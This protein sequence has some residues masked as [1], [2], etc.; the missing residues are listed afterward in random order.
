[1]PRSGRS[2][3]NVQRAASVASR[4]AVRITSRRAASSAVGVMR[5]TLSRAPAQPDARER[6]DQRGVSCLT[7]RRTDKPP[8]ND[9]RV[10]RA[11]SHAVDR[12]AIIDAV[13]IKGE[14]SPAIARG[15]A[16]WS[17]RIDQLGAG[18]K[19]YQH[20]PREARRLLAEAGFPNGS[21]PS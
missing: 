21:R 6:L 17:A 9:V 3:R 19:Y 15:L 13:Y 14:P 2:T 18:A 7:G 10:R 16:E 4:S 12:Q 11:I 5:R 20:D 8:F 1:M